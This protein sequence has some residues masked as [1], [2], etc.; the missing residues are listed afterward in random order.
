[1]PT[2]RHLSFPLRGDDAGAVFERQGILCAALADGVGSYSGGGVAAKTAIDFVE[3]FEI[4]I[5][6]QDFSRLFEECLLHLSNSAKELRLGTTLTV[7]VNAGDKVIFGHVGDCRLYHLRGDG[8]MT[9]THDQTEVAYL[10]QQG[11][12]NRYDA[13]TY[14]RANVLMSVLAPNKAYTLETGAF[15]V[16]EGDRLILCSDGFYKGLAKRLIRDISVTNLEFDE[17]A[18][19][20]EGAISLAKKDDDAS[21][22]IIQI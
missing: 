9:A 19:G 21:A 15:G 17:F 18:R 20:I 22:L 3:K 16:R 1:M 8:L 12:L 7:L 4:P 11:V 6:E 10:Q 5:V 2:W 14:H 13:L